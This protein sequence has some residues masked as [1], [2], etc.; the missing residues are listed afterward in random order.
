MSKFKDWANKFIQYADS[1]DSVSENELLKPIDEI[2]LHCRSE[3]IRIDGT[4]RLS[5][6]VNNLLDGAYLHLIN[7]QIKDKGFRVCKNSNCNKLFIPRRG[8]QKYCTKMCQ[9]YVNVTDWRNRR[10]SQMQDGN[11]TLSN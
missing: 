7:R 2:L 4:L 10:K 3:A 6:K 5:L 8:N 1:S 11:S 9:N